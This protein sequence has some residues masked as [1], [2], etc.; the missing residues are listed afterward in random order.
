MIKQYVGLIRH[1]EYLQKAK[2]PS[3]FQAYGLNELGMSQAR[4]CVSVLDQFLNNNSDIERVEIHSSGLL[5]GWQTAQIFY[6]SL[7]KKINAQFFESHDLNER[8]VGS[9][10]NLT[11]DEIETILL[12]DP[13]YEMPMDNWKSNSYYR[14]PYPGAESLMEAGE[15]VKNY[16]ENVLNSADRHR[17]LF[18]IVGH[19]AALRHAAYH[20]NLLEV[21]QISE[22]SMYHA[23]PILFSV[24]KNN[25]TH[26][27]G[28]WKVRNN[29]SEALD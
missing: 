24:V 28:Q 10:A 25:W 7:R 15:R 2:T 12:N 11:V 17:K 22:L 9:L 3:A 19:G 5:R 14:L 4:D 6:Q 8:S 18:L 21:K 27:E 20:L 26:I 1:G 29:Q 23:H 13:R 16:I